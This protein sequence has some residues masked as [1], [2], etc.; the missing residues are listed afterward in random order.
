MSTSKIF[1]D[2]I[3]NYT[4]ITSWGDNTEEKFYYPITKRQYDSLAINKKKMG[5]IL[6]CVI[7]GNNQPSKDYEVRLL[8]KNIEYINL[9]CKY[10]PLK[11]KNWP[12]GFRHFI[13][14]ER[15]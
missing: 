11:C 12:W 9:E 1:L 2:R 5:D 10:G 7:K 14:V 13:R 15:V 4:Q 3:D 6:K 8:A